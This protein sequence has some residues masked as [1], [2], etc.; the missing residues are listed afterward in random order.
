MANLNH[1]IDTLN[2]RIME[3]KNRRRELKAYLPVEGQLKS[4]EEQIV[5]H[6]EALELLKA[7][8]ATNSRNET[9]QLKIDL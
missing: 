8:Q 3:L 1:A 6:K 9:M 7:R 5:S 4:L 2:G